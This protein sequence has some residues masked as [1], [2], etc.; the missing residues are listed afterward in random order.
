MNTMSSQ[1]KRHIYL[2]SIPVDSREQAMM[3]AS[4]VCWDIIE[5]L[6]KCGIR[7]MT[8]K[9]ILEESK[10]KGYPQSTIYAA[11][12][13]LERAA[14]ITSR[15]PAFRWGRRGP[16]EKVLEKRL[17][18]DEPRGG[19]PRKIYRLHEMWGVSFDDDFAESLDPI[20]KKH[21]PQLK[22]IWFRILDNIVEEYK[23]TEKLREFYPKDDICPDCNLE[24]DAHEFLTAI[25]FG[26]VNFLEGEKEWEEIAKKY[27][28]MK[29]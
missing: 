5:V 6:R 10:P 20:V 14:W 13:Q 1:E 29:K 19:R 18:R 2:T 12:T 24:H 25:S 28:F 16:E 4:E 11:L 27:G 8:A 26:I 23:T 3:L 15:R 9:E 7:G 21:T 22:E 17:G